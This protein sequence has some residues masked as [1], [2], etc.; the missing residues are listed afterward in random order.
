MRRLLA[1]YRRRIVELGKRQTGYILTGSGA[2][3]FE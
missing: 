1:W 3:S 2:D